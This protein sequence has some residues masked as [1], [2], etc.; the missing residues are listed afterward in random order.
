MKS[1]GVIAVPT[2]TLYGLCAL[3]EN[4]DRLYRLKRRPNGKPLG[5]F[6]DD[7]EEIF[8]YLINLEINNRGREIF[9][10]NLG[11]RFCNVPRNFLFPRYVLLRS[12]PLF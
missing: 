9:G 8:K 6:M 5:L 7:G 1:G 12:L 11:N 2:D 3:A 4:S 10:R